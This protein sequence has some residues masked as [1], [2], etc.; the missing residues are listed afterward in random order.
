MELVACLR[1]AVE[2]RSVRICEVFFVTLKLRNLDF[3]PDTAYPCPARIGGQPSPSI[4]LDHEA[5]SSRLCLRCSGMPIDLHGSLLAPHAPSRYS[6]PVQVA[7]CRHGACMMSVAVVIYL[8]CAAPACT[9]SA[10]AAV[11][12]SRTRNVA[13]A[14]RRRPPARSACRFFCNTSS[15][16]LLLECTGCRLPVPSSRTSRPFSSGSI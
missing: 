13:S 12:Y 16:C 7:S 9:A 14:W 15:L 8:C 6:E 4:D 11:L 3:F 1:S 10:R 5:A 2:T